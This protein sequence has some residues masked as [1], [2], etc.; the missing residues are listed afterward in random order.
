MSDGSQ[1]VIPESEVDQLRQARLILQQEAAAVGQLADNLGPDFPRAVRLLTECSGSVIV[2]GIGKAGLIARKIVAT[3]SST[4]T[5]AQFLH[6]VEA[7]HGDLGC[8]DANDVV[9]ALS[10]SGETEEVLRLLDVF[11][12]LK[13][14]VIAF[15]STLQNSLARGATVALAIGKLEEAGTHKLAPSTSTTAM[16]A[17]GDALALVTSRAKGFAQNDFARLHPGGSLG[18][19]LK[20]VAEIMRPVTDVRVAN[21]ANTVRDVL[22]KMHTDRRRS[23]AILFTNDDGI[24]T[25]LFTDSD[26]VRLLEQRQEEFFDRPARETMS[27]SPLTVTGEILVQDAVEL[28]SDRKFSELPV[29]DEQHR[30]VGLVDITDVIGLTADAKP[31]ADLRLMDSNIPVDNASS[32]NQ[33]GQKSA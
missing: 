3:M 18:M 4:G 28:L 23:G 31:T 33:P 17:L 13:T 5:R 6:P 7:L 16:L 1:R 25:G 8:V 14:P 10:N 24:L 32:E 9:L 12:N 22:T 15:T 30:P 2:T 19:K 27:Q 20:T 26:L 21:E 29:V 11:R